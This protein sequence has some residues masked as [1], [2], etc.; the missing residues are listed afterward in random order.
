MTRLMAAAMLLIAATMPAF[1]CDWMKSVSTDSQS[2]TVASQ[3]ANGQQTPP[4]ATD[5]APS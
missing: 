4:P 3:P 2:S 1:A 5:R